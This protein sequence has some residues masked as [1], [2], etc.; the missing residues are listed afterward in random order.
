MKVHILTYC[1]DIERLHA[2]LM[3][4]ETLRTGF[5]NAEVF[6]TDGGSCPEAYDRIQLQAR[7]VGC[8][9]FRSDISQ[10][11]WLENTIE[12]SNEPL[13]ILHPDICF[14]KKMF[15]TESDAWIQAR[16]IRPFY[17]G[18]H[19]AQTYVGASTSV[20]YVSRPDRIKELFDCAR[21]VYPHFDPYKPWQFFDTNVWKFFDVFFN[22]INL[23]GSRV[24]TFT[25]EQL[26]C[27]DHLFC[28]T[29]VKGVCKK[30]GS[31][32]YA[33]MLLEVDEYAKRTLRLPSGIYVRQEEFFT[34]SQL[35]ALCGSSEE[36]NQLH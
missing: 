25:K 3:V 2:S 30:I 35:E 11:E 26:D 4:F 23:L 9:V 14:H 34:H 19:E 32:L 27:Y 28:G 22:G 33:K 12:S 8:N 21:N 1:K 5:P 16:K 31:D 7:N 29:N 10:T 13:V 17:S 6:V 24:Q 20:F 36:I 18:F 15:F